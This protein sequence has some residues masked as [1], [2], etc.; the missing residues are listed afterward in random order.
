[1][2]M[3]FF[4]L[5]LL[6]TVL[7]H[8]SMANEEQHTKTR[9][10]ESYFEDQGKDGGSGGDDRKNGN[11]TP[12]HRVDDNEDAIDDPIDSQCPEIPPNGCSVCG[13]GKCITNQD[14]IFHFPGQ[15]KVPCN[16]LQEAGYQGLIPLSQCPFLPNLIGVC[17]CSTSP[18][19]MSVEPSSMGAGGIFGISIAIVILVVLGVFCRM[20]YIKTRKEK[21]AEVVSYPSIR[22][23]Q[24]EP[25]EEAAPPKIV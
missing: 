21:L 25:A 9:M 6:V 7:Q 19:P 3:T 18:D 15:P 4:K 10:L 23:H 13:K 22:K 12:D 20:K 16:Q 1:M 11:D 2:M 24:E 5:I 8:V 14:A 17:R